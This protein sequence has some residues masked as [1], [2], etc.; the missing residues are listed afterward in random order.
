MPVAS[1]LRQQWYRNMAVS[2]AQRPAANTRVLIL[3][4][5]TTLIFQ[6][7]VADIHAGDL[8]SEEPPHRR[9]EYKYSFKGPHLSQTDGSIP[10]WIHT[11]SKFVPS[12][13]HHRAAGQ[14]MFKLNV[15]VHDN[16]DSWGSCS[17]FAMEAASAQAVEKWQRFAF[18]IQNC[19]GECIHCAPELYVRWTVIFKRVLGWFKNCTLKGP[20]GCQSVEL[21]PSCKK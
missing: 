18:F 10:F 19:T 20:D 7:S 4:F 2:I 5:L 8:T 9:F 21:F 3:T 14:L 11:G 12:C 17:R 1:A 15:N 16:E 13:Q 6:C